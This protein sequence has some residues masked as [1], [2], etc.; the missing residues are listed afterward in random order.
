M[1]IHKPVHMLDGSA[2]RQRT[3]NREAVLLETILIEMAALNRS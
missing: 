1:R 2:R 3:D